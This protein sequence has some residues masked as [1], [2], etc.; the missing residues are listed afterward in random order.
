[1]NELVC[2]KHLELFR[3]QHYINIRPSYI[4]RHS[5]LLLYVEFFF[6]FCLQDFS[7]GL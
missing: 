3:E 1:M 2:F 4:F 5:F 7:K 6:F